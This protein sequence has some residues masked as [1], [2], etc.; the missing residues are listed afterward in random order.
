M[1]MKKD[2]KINPGFRLLTYVKAFEESQGLE[3]PFQ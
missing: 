3:N 1:S 2:A